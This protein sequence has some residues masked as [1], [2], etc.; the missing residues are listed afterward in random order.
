MGF[1]LSECGESGCWRDSQID[2][3]NALADQ[4]VAQV[5]ATAPT[6]EQG[7]PLSGDGDHFSW[8]RKMDLV[9][10]CIEAIKQSGFGEYLDVFRI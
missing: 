4:H 6:I 9:A 3:R 1:K 8:K 7:A 5:L 10:S 2:N